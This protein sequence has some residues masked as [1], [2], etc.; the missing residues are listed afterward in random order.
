MN[1]LIRIKKLKFSYRYNRT[2]GTKTNNTAAPEV[3]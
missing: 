1:P 2:A 3:N